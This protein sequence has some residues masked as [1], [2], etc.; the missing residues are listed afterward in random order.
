MN[1]SVSKS[2]GE[3]GAQPSNWRHEVEQ[4]AEAFL[5]VANLGGL[6]LTA[7]D[8]ELEFLSAPHQPPSRLPPGKMA[9]YAFW[10]DGCWLKVGKVGANSSARYTSQHY[11]PGSARSTLA[12]SLLKCAII[13][14]NSSFDSENPGSWLKR[15]SHR[16]NILLPTDLPYELLSLLE[17]FLHL[18][19]KPR[20]E[21]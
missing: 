6:T 20:Y 15:H 16:V 2:G 21:G 3:K 10:A 14:C 13:A 7:K 9:V 1:G 18:R 5:T 12:G 11:N 4:A 17:A 19:L 8:L